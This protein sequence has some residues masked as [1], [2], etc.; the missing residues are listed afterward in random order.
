MFLVFLF[1]LPWIPFEYHLNMIGATKD[2]TAEIWAYAT[3][4]WEIFSNG[5]RPTLSEFYAS[6]RRLPKPRDCPEDMYEI[7][8][9]G[10]H[11]S[12]DRRFTPQTVFSKLFLA[13]KFY[14]TV[15]VF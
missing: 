13:R 12:P 9:E 15:K 8:K 4:L 2:F 10:W 6:K 5:R 14:F 11:E 1:S 7:M 3:T